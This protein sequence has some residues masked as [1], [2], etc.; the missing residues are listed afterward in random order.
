MEEE[1]DKKPVT[2]YVPQFTPE[3]VEKLLEDHADSGFIQRVKKDLEDPMWVKLPK[4]KEKFKL[5]CIIFQKL[6]W[7]QGFTWGDW[8]KPLEM[9]VEHEPIDPGEETLLI[10]SILE[11]Y[12]EENDGHQKQEKG[13]P[14]RPLIGMGLFYALYKNIDDF[15]NIKTDGEFAYP[16][17][18]I[19][20]HTAITHALIYGDNRYK[21]GYLN[22]LIEGGS[23]SGYSGERGGGSKEEEG[24]DKMPRKVEER[25]A[26][27]EEEKKEE[28]LFKS[29]LVTDEEESRRL[30]KVILSQ[31]NL[32]FEPR[33]DVALALVARTPLLSL[34]NQ[35]R[36]DSGDSIFRYPGRES[37]FNLDL[38]YLRE[39]YQDVKRRL[40]TNQWEFMLAMLVY[41]ALQAL[42]EKEKVVFHYMEE[43]CS[44][45]T[46]EKEIFIHIGK[47]KYYADIESKIFIPPFKDLQE[48]DLREPY[49]SDMETVFYNYGIK[50]S[51]TFFQFL[52]QCYPVIFG[53][54]ETTTA[55]SQLLYGRN[56][57]VQEYLY[58][59]FRG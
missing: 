25:G 50:N 41:V 56:S 9:F 46:A 18:F 51:A 29:T 35:I 33:F 44:I 30:L 43:Q 32:V 54:S 17:K 24:G 1:E 55:L 6:R 28:P 23:G 47:Q 52:M 15:R 26:Y 7:Q 14:V 58:F 42:K 10:E 37:K 36:S 53:I 2:G 45:G 38:T 59:K 22:S 40:P 48:M 39:T 34:S 49:K 11:R 3:E 13:D 27:G 57:F 21:A 4:S 12:D 19:Q 16:K 31:T 8:Q 5:F 20:F